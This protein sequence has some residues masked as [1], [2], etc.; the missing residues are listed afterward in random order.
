MSEPRRSQALVQVRRTLPA[1]PIEAFRAWTD[2]RL[3]SQ[4]FKPLGGS[5]GE[6]EMDVRVGGSS[7]EIEVR[8]Q[9]RRHQQRRPGPK[10]LKGNARSPAL[11]IPRL[12]RCLHQAIMAESNPCQKCL[13]PRQ[14]V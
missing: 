11:R 9:Q 14:T 10:H 3:L 6:V 13:F 8:W 4:W 2:P 5:S 1:P 12:W 7:H